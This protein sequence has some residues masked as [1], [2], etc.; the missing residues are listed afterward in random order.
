MVGPIHEPPTCCWLLFDWDRVEVLEVPDL[1]PLRVSGK[2]ENTEIDRD[3]EE[4][5][6][7]HNWHPIANATWAKCDLSST[8]LAHDLQLDTDLAQ[9]SDEAE[10]RSE[11]KRHCEESHKTKLNYSLVIVEN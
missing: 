3:R 2:Q 11:G 6:E 1:L 7:A 4:W 9:I 8:I 10:E 5:K